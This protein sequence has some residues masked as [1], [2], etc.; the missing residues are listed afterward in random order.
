MTHF[1][2]IKI[3][4][5]HLRNL[6]QNIKSALLKNDIKSREIENLLNR[7]FDL[8]LSKRT[9]QRYYNEIGYKYVGYKIKQK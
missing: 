8:N 5:L 4:I 3:Q 6:D 2:T 9:V 7:R 1:L